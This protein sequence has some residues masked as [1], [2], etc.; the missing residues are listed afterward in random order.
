MHNT[1][2]TCYCYGGNINV[3]GRDSVNDRQCDRW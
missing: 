3:N 1:Y 2:T